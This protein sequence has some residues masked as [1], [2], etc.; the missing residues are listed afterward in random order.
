LG[1]IQNQALLAESSGLI[2]ERSYESAK[3][4]ESEAADHLYTV[5]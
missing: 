1:K 5:A 4:G 3:I 2:M